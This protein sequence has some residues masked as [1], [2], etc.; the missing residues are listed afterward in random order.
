MALSLVLLSNTPATWDVEVLTRG[1]VK[2]LP[3]L[4]AT[5]PC[6]VAPDVPFL[7]PDVKPDVAQIQ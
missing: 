6:N 2:T 5:D 3:F 4:L 7:R 1:W